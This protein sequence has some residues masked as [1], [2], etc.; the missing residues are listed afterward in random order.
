MSRVA[1]WFKKRSET[2]P[3]PER[4]LRILVL[5]ISLV[6][7]ILLEQLGKQHDWELRFTNSPPSGF[8]L[9]SQSHFDLILCDRNQFGYPWRE[10][11]SRL[12]GISPRSCILLVSPVNHDYLW[13]DVLQH[14]GYDVLARPMR[15]SSVLSAVAAA[16]RF[17]SPAADSWKIAP[18]QPI[19]R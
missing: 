1:D 5:A 2:G 10:V 4:R 8:S 16:V 13:Q 15:E 18:A 3:A 6:D 17:L 7:R 9:A 19:R 12:A 11:I 14:G